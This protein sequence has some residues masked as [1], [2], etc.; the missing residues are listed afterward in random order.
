L[1]FALVVD[2]YGELLG[3]VTLEDI[4]EEVVGQIDD[5]HDLSIDKVTPNKDGSITVSADISIRDLNRE[6][7]W[8]IGDGEVSTI[9]GL[10]YHLARDIPKIGQTLLLDGY[11]FKIVRKKGNKLLRVRIHLN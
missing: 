5:E 11:K 4:L 3:L 8:D 6:M 10:M 1:H 2:E 9:S 7:N